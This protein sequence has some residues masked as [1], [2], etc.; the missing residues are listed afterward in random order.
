MPMLRIIAFAAMAMAAMPAAAQVRVVVDGHVQDVP[1]GVIRTVT[2]TPGGAQRIVD[3]PYAGATTPGAA[4]ITTT[5][6]TEE[7]DRGRALRTTMET[8]IEPQGGYAQP[9]TMVY[10][11][12]PQGQ[13]QQGYP[14]QAAYRQPDYDA[15]DISQQAGYQP[16][17]PRIELGESALGEGPSVAGAPDQGLRIR[18]NRFSGHFIAPVMI[19]GVKLHAII[20][21][22]AT[23]TILS[24]DDARASHADQDVIRTEGAVGIGGYTQVGVTRVR[25][26]EIGGHNLGSFVVRIGQQG[27]PQTLLGQTEIARLGRITIE[28][29]VMTIYPRGVQMASR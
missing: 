9:Q 16:Q 26:L 1:A 7:D 15:P 22:G 19:N 11:I 14:Q 4:T 8:R 2:Y 23:Y 28:G 17:P 29:D 12:P 6:T 10:V 5:E 20:D 21:T 24:Q 3:R 18:R 13:P 27:I 25:S